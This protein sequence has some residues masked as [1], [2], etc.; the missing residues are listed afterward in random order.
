M[1]AIDLAPFLTMR[2]H[3][4]IVHHVPG[5]VRLRVGVAL[6]KELGGVDTALFDRILG[7]IEGIKDVRVNP[8]AASVVI[9]YSPANL[10]PSWWDT[11]VTGADAQAMELLE[12]LLTTNLARAAEVVQSH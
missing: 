8:A 3:L 5:R 12:R 2:R 9:S 1:T 7:A 11:L 6:F 4:K 10:E